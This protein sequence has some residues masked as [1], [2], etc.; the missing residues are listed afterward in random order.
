MKKLISILILAIFV[1]Q[2]V[3]VHA[4]NASITNGKFVVT[5]YYSPLPNQSYYMKGSY[6]ADVV[7]NGRGTNGASGKEVFIGMLAAPKKY[8]FG[9][10]IHLE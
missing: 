6:E 4:D 5:A 8:P 10:K 1:L 2:L 9:T 7:L 3:P